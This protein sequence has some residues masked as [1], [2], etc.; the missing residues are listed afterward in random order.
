MR[1]L[2]GITNSMDLNLRKLWEW[3][4]EEPDYSP[5]GHGELDMTWRLNNNNNKRGKSLTV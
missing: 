2:N 1:W 3:R 4:T 5:W